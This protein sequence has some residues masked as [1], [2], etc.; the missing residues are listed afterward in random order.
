MSE[1][2]ALDW[3][4]EALRS[5]PKQDVYRI[6]KRLLFLHDQGLSRFHES[7]PS[8][9]RERA[10]PQGGYITAAE[11]VRRYKF[12]KRFFTSGAGKQLPFVK[13]LTPRKTLVHEPRLVK[14]IESKPS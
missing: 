6:L 10:T 12:P 9:R 2:E 14:W 11:A 1:R 7:P 4:E 13:R 3:I 8:P 5:G